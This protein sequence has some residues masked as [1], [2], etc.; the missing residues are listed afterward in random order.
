MDVLKIATAGSVDDGKSTLIGRLL[1]E[2]NSI[3]TDKL[4]AIEASSKK[5]GLDYIDLS[6]LTD[7]LIAEREQGI[8]IDV[9]HIYFSTP[10]R[11]FIIADTPGHFEY[12]RNMVTGASNANVS[13]I[14]VDA[15]N[16]VVE[17]TFRHFYIS[18]LLRIP[19]VV[20][21]INKMDLVG[22]S[23]TAFEEIQTKFMAFAEKVKFEGQQISF[24]PVSSLYGENLTAS[25]VSMPWYT[26]APLLSLLEEVTIDE[27]LPDEESRFPVQ[28]VVRPKS[29]EFHDYRAYAG[30]VAS[31]LL[32]KG[33]R[34]VVLPSGQET[35]IAKIEK[36]GREIEA[37]QAKESVSILLEDDVD[38]S[39]GDMIVPFAQLPK[40]GRQLDATIC[41]MDKKPLRVGGTYLVQHGV[42]ISKAK[43]SALTNL[44]D[45]VTLEANDTISALQLNEI[46]DVQLKTAKEIF[47]DSFADNK[48]NGSFIVIDE[49]TN[50]TVGVGLI[51]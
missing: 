44:I 22:Y 6:L 26:G 21:C 9:A 49:Q 40:Q 27:Q 36:F 23:Q 31:G 41:W 19:N 3:T 43:I 46:A 14:L 38:I 11:K 39:R 12:T 16:G 42:N 4:Q 5:K 18:C 35:T 17:Q 25:S 29:E 28:Y 32:R 8:T 1:F 47:Y 37:A 50:A 10:T 34:V 20:V 24:I 30:K 45:V 33:E 15:R 48:A 2:T 7:G 13:M 51:K